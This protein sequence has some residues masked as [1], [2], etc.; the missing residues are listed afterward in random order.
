M[1]TK[2]KYSELFSVNITQRYYDN[3]KPAKN[4]IGPVLDYA[5]HATPQ[6]RALLNRLD[7]VTKVKPNKGGFTVWGRTQGPSGA[8]TLLYFKPRKGD[9]LTFFINLNNPAFLSYNDLPTQLPADHIYYFNNEVTDAAAPKDN[10]HLN[11]DPLR[12]SNSDAIKKATGTYEYIH[13]A[14]LNP[15]AAK[16]KH[17]ASGY[18]ALPSSQNNQGGQTFLSFNLAGFPTGMCEL[19]IGGVKVETA[20]HWND[21]LGA[22]V[23]AIMEFSLEA[24]AL[25]NYRIVEADGSITPQ[26]PQYNLLFMNRAT[27]WRYTMVLEQNSPLYRELIAL[28]PAEKA[29]FMNR[30][31]VISNDTA[32]VFVPTVVSD[33]HFEFVSNAPKALQERYISSSSATGNSLTLALKKYVNHPTIPEEDIKVNLPY[34]EA[35]RLDATNDPVIYS[36]VRLTL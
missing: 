34:P 26:R 6:C 12:V 22:D 20:Y 32:V 24:L 30:I 8:N 9:V 14:V 21:Q 11:I 25:P 4:S 2:V 18:E 23:F 33:T 36:D 29:D 17:I 3:D 13:A 5:L 35:H 7:L 1:G 10:L 28:P 15:G 19:Q 31:N 16:L 27:L